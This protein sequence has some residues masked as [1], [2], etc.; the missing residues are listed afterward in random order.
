[1][2][3]KKA[4]K[5]HDSAYTVFRMLVGLLFFQHGAQKVL[6]WFGAT[7]V[8]LSSMMGVAGI[9]ELIGGLAIFL[10]LFTRLFAL[11][12]GV[13]MLAAYFMVHSGNNMIPIINQ[14]ELALLY[15]ATFII[16]FIHGNKKMNLES[17]LFKK[18][19]F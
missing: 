13:E 9:I 12:S 1:M 17:M 7:A 19:F 6:G 11:I 4:E 14:G 15:F 16:L 3:F 18:E 10:G 8:P 5:Y 2:F